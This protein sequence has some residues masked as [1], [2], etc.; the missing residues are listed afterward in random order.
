[1]TSRPTGSVAPRSRTL[2]LQGNN[3]SIF[4]DFNRFRSDHKLLAVVIAAGSTAQR[5]DG[6]LPFIEHLSLLNKQG[7]PL[8]PLIGLATNEGVLRQMKTAG[9][10]H[11]V[12]Y[13]IEE[14]PE[15]LLNILE[16]L[17]QLGIL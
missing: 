2:K 5:F 4:S 13:T 9:C 3:G 17:A 1:M 16:G 14:Y 6:G 11:V 8:L 10:S 15:E 7:E 12:H